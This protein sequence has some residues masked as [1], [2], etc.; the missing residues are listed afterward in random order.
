MS[1]VRLSKIWPPTIFSTFLTETLQQSRKLSTVIPVGSWTRQSKSFEA[2]AVR[3]ATV[4]PELTP[5]LTPEGYLRLTPASADTDG[6]F[7]AVLERVR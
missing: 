2:F 7:V 3:A 1:D 5:F 6:F 4:D